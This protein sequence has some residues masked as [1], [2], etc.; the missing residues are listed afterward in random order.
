ME[1]LDEILDEAKKASNAASDSDL[2]RKMGIS[3]PTMA[4]YRSRRSTPDAYALMQLQKILKKDAR[5]LLAIIEAER[6]KDEKRR[7]YWQDVKKSFRT[8]S[9]A[10]L[11]TVALFLSIG[12][13]NKADAAESY[14]NLSISMYI[15]SS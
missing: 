13:P 9:A 6:A 11:A 10:T 2:A 12:Q 7:E 15:M 8:T 14:S 3:Q 4:H 5:E 1:N